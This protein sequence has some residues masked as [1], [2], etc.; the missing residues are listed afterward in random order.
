MVASV[1]WLV[2]ETGVPMRGTPSELFTIPW[3]LPQWSSALES[4]IKVKRR[5]DPI[6]AERSFEDALRCVLA[7]REPTARFVVR[8]GWSPI[9]SGQ[10]PNTA[11]G[12]YMDGRMLSSGS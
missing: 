11:K 7:D 6:A 5:I 10:L 3:M 4:W 8:T 1:V 12:R 9:G 2:T